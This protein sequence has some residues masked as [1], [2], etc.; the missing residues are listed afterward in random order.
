MHASTHIH[1]VTYTFTHTLTH[2]HTHTHTNTLFSYKLHDSHT[3]TQVEMKYKGFL[4]TNTGESCHR[5]LLRKNFFTNQP[6]LQVRVCGYGARLCR[7]GCGR[8]CVRVGVG[9]GVGVCVCACVCVCV[10]E[11][12]GR[13]ISS[14]CIVREKLQGNTV[15]IRQLESE[16]SFPF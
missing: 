2:T 3:S 5:G 11:G 4:N 10:F 14:M 6:S 1:T 15:S 7:C 12:K 8:G 16:N 13:W 9:V